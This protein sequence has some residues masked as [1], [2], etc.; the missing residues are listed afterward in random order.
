M[1]EPNTDPLDALTP[2]TH[3]DTLTLLNKH[4]LKLF[5]MYWVVAMQAPALVTNVTMLTCKKC[6]KVLGTSYV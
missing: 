3:T 4:I 5:K 6:A 1:P 2:Q